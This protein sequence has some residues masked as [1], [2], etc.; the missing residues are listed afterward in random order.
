MKKISIVFSF[1]A[2]A[3]LLLSSCNKKPQITSALVT[4]TD[5]P[6]HIELQLDNSSVLYPTNVAPGR[7]NKTV[8][9]L[10]N[11]K[12]IKDVTVSPEIKEYEVELISLD[13]IRTKKFVETLGE[14][15]KTVYGNDRVEIVHDWV[16]IAEDGYLTLKI[17]FHAGDPKK[18]HTFNL[19]RVPS[20]KEDEYNFELR[21]NADNDIYGLEFKGI[22]AFDLNDLMP[23]D[24]SDIK[25][26]LKWDG[27]YEE[28]KK[29]DLVMS[30][31]KNL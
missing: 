5:T 2:T 11:Y 31:R 21:H 28:G 16:S 13:T 18:V 23:L 27:F 7:Y 24:G 20:A 10:T 17:R 1:L 26:H 29:A 30:F 12:V 9:A 15:D 3:A 19:V 8:R 6:D 14:D 25:F 4:L 22:I